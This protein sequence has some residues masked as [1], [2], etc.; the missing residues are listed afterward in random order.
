MH[1]YCYFKG[2]IK[3]G[4]RQVVCL[5]KVTMEDGKISAGVQTETILF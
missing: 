4:Q 5:F 2:T 1:Y 3:S